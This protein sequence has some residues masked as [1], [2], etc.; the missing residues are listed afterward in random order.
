MREP[1]S[2]CTQS[3]DLK[4]KMEELLARVPGDVLK[5]RRAK[6]GVYR[7]SNYLKDQERIRG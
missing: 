6:T 7:T 1:T 5:N 2:R 3:A 4:F